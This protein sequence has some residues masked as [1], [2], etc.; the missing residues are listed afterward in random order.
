MAKKIDSLNCYE[1]QN[2]NDQFLETEEVKK[3][4]KTFICE[5][6]FYHFS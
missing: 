2:Q 5:G 1:H 6:Y 3:K 4:T